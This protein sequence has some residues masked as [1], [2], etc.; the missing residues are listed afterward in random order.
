MADTPESNRDNADPSGSGEPMTMSDVNAWFVREVLPLEAGL[1]RFFSRR[2]RNKKDIE[3]LLQDVYMR[4]Y[5]AAQKE[6]PHPVRPF[7]FTVARNLLIN[8][9]RREH[10]VA[11]QSV[12]D[13]DLLNVSDEE[14]GPERNVMAREELVRLQEAL[15]QLPPRAR[16]AVIL[17]KIDGLSR[18][19]I[20]G[21]MGIT[22]QTVNRHLTD[23]MY[24]LAELLYGPPSDLRGKS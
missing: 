22:E 4:V 24:E 17:R 11:I 5:E 1:I 12:A 20:A 18:R 10:V 13:V 7:V 9:S 14:P 15:D 8:R 3:D 21:R 2:W 16:Q 23:A 19:E 6:V